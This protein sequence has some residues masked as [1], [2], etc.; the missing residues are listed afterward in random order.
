MRARGHT[1]QHTPQM[2]FEESGNKCTVNV[3]TDVSGYAGDDDATTPV[4]GFECDGCDL[5]SCALGGGYTVSAATGEKEWSAVDLAADWSEYDDVVE[6]PV[7]I[8]SPTSVVASVARKSAS[9]KAKKAAAV[10]EEKAARKAVA[11]DGTTAERKG[12]K[13]KSGGGGG[14][15]GGR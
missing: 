13:G 7:S 3:V 10:D 8:M 4:V 15:R 2:T 9:P 5:V 1:T 6:L 14:G 12:G 11:A